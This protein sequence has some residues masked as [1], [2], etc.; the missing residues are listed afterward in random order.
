MPTADPSPQIVD[1]W[2]A[3][4][5]ASTRWNCLLLE[6]EKVHL[7]AAVEI[8]CNEFIIMKKSA[9]NAEQ[10]RRFFLLAL[11]LCRRWTL[12][13]WFVY[14]HIVVVVVVVV[15]LFSFQFFDF[16]SLPLLLDSRSILNVMRS[17]KWRRPRHIQHWNEWNA[18]TYSRHTFQSC[19]KVLHAECVMRRQRHCDE[20]KVYWH[21]HIL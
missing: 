14:A 15:Y 17:L 10:Q 16:R 6:K 11:S 3:G 13:T 9:R 21:F 5:F 2:T 7:A 8:P 4:A 18:H 20:T 19:W 1:S 12:H